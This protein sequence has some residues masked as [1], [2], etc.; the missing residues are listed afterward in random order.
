MS[1]VETYL[2]FYGNCA[3]ALSYYEKTIGA[4]VEFKMTFG[5][6]PMGAETPPDFTSRI[7]HSS[8]VINGQR[9]MASDNMPGQPNEGMHGFTLCLVY[10]SVAEGEKVF[11]ALAAGG[12]VGM[13]MQETFWVERWGSLVDKFGTPWMVNAGKSKM[14]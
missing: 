14:G 6:S 13:P 12:K 8:M 7:M 1:G 5:E 9:I 10:D 11:D 3:D 2:T 4:N